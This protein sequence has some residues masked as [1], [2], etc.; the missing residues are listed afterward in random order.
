[1]TPR[2]VSQRAQTGPPARSTDNVATHNAVAFL[3]GGGEMGARMRAYDWTTTPLGPPH[4][5]TQSLRT[6]VRIMLDSRYAM[7]MLWGPDLTF[8][9]NDAY[10][11]TVGIK[12]DWVLGAR[13]DKVWAEIWPDIGPRIEHVRNTGEATWDEGLLL[14]LERSGYPEETYHTFS[15]SPVY[16]DDATVAGMLC[17]VTEDTER[18]LSERRIALLG[19]IGT[20]MA[21]IKS[22][23]EVFA[24]LDRH[25]G[26]GVADLPCT[27]TYVQGERESLARRVAHTGF[28]A[29][30]AIAAMPVDTELR[31][32]IA[33]VLETATE[34]V[35]D[36]VEAQTPPLPAGPWREP[37]RAALLLP[38]QQQ[39]QA[40]PAGVFV[41]FLNR[42]RPLDDA[43]R[44]FLDLL[45]AQI[46]SGLANARSYAEE[47]RRTEALA[48]LDRAKTAFFS[49]VSHEFRTPLTLMMGPL[50]ELL[51]DG[52]EHLAD[53]L[54]ASLA[55]VHRNCLRLLKLVNSLLDFS[56]LEAGRLQARY[57][58]VDIGA[59]TAELAG[60]FRPAVERAGLTLRV[61]CETVRGDVYVDASMLEKIVFNLLSNA[62]KHT[63]AG[64]IRVRVAAGREH[65]VL[66]VADTGVG[67]PPEALGQVFDRFYRVPNARS[68]TYEG[69]GIGLALVQELVK[70]H[71][72]TIGVTSIVDEGTAFTVSLPYGNAHLP[73]HHLERDGDAKP[74]GTQSS[75]GYVDEA[76]GWLPPSPPGEIPGSDVRAGAPLS[77]TVL[78][79]DDNADMREYLRKLLSP[80][81]NVVTAIDG[82]E[83]LAAIDAR[84]PDLVL[85]DVM[86]PKLDGFALLKALRGNDRTRDIPVV[87][88]S[89]RA[90][91]ESRIEGIDAGAD[92]YVVKPFSV[93]ELHARVSSNLAMARARR[94]FSHA[95][96]ENEARRSFLLTLSDAL[97]AMSSTAAVSQCAVDHIGR[98][99]G[100]TAAG[101]GEI[102]ADATTLHVT[103]QWHADGSA[104]PPAA[105]IDLD[106]FGLAVTTP[107]GAPIVIDDTRRHD[108]ARAWVDAGVGAIIAV[109]Q[110]T[111][112]RTVAM[113]WVSVPGSRAWSAEE[114][115]LLRESA[116]RVWTELS[117][118]RAENALR[119]SEER[120]RAMADSSPLLVWVID[121]TGRVNFVNRAYCEFFGIPPDTIEHGGW[122]PL[123]HPDDASGYIAE[124]KAA[125]AEQRSFSAMARVRRNDGEWRWIQSFGAPRFAADGRFLGAVGS[126]PDITEL[127]DA[128][129]TLREADRRKDEFLAT[130]AHELRNP[131]AP[132]RQAARLSRSPNA[133]EAQRRWSQDVI[134]RQVQQMALLLDDLLDVSRITRGKLELR[135]QRVQL[136][137]V[138][139]A[140]LE[141]TRPLLDERRQRL[142]TSLPAE[143]VWLNADPLRVAQILA[144]L[145]TNAAKYSEPGGR[146]DLSAR[147]HDD[148]LSI[149]VKDT[150]IGIESELLSRVFEMFS[151]VKSSLDRAE[152]GL[153][154][155]LALVKG[156]VELHD[157]TV[158][159]KSDGLGKGAEFVVALPLPARGQQP[160]EI[161]G[162]LARNET[163]ARTA[164]ILVAD[165]NRDAAASLA[166]LLQLD[167][168]EITVANDGRVAL[169]AAEAFRPHVALLDIGMPKLNGY[170]VARHIRAEPWGKA[171]ILVAM[172]GWGQAED[173]RRA[174]EAGFDHHF[175]KPL[176]LEVLDAFLADALAEPR[177]VR[178]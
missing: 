122:T 32:P 46:A 143:P 23:A 86:M 76:L 124:V 73:A 42:Y 33:R 94:N 145:L 60:V 62:F 172:T 9:C 47:R 173:K 151:Q 119:E 20:D 68:R 147:V 56:R 150:G 11:P 104:T 43:Y 48:E 50:E 165:D 26:L 149:S 61:E 121:P 152:G 129:D 158:E 134:E 117:R 29:S 159:A 70:L 142:T 81:F 118:A 74:L 6:V 107:D 34:F 154:I 112:G 108:H 21:S 141:T 87:L 89:A 139:E 59:M 14:F 55:V 37:P 111:D 79:V 30:P 115:A 65:A 176:D 58:K 67:I 153:G 83:A 160:A 95:A 136:A 16:D 17:V 36:D 132:I 2:R 51:R 49:N 38:I 133:T 174:F 13:S 27:L 80:R 138:V 106:R 64:E 45:V 35:V 5:W 144:N 15:Y 101:Y 177:T 146:V 120:F 127:I 123:L 137:S 126:S 164:R 155:G 166:T 125:L 97:R 168:H 93:R 66:T 71:G 82:A 162:G 77:D 163:P 28:G 31:W 39:G 10:L 102:D 99:L 18:Q 3:D 1:M 52:G 88:L 96:R 103:S 53:D 78:V 90:G 8:F 84:L 75:T 170:E 135:M 72:G 110:V 40:R 98:Q 69:S 128:S 63:L 161:A 109:S 156:L 130:L 178:P 114:V 100:A 12:R 171:V 105:P 85:T 167:G 24:V 54:R 140:A 22:E 19:A 57:E 113:L 131:L 4:T 7:W 44:R 25:I 157:G 91:E 41:A 175:T 148:R 169:A 92:D 116:V